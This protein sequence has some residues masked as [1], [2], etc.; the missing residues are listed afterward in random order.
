MRTPTPSDGCRAGVWLMQ[1]ANA[2]G[3][4]L[5]TSICILIHFRVGAV[6]SAKD[7]MKSGF[8]GAQ[9]VAQYV[10]CGQMPGSGELP[11]LLSWPSAKETSRQAMGSGGTRS[12]VM[13]GAFGTTLR[14]RRR[15][16]IVC[17][18]Q[19]I[20]VTDRDSTAGRLELTRRR[21]PDLGDQTVRH[22]FGRSVKSQWP[23]PWDRSHTPAAN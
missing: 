16:T 23:Q 10:V 2:V 5:R 4:K 11:G 7:R 21:P 20:L 1:L 9:L 22:Q 8:Q 6:I 19:P 12:C 15:T 17:C 18:Y 3:F 13:P 14:R